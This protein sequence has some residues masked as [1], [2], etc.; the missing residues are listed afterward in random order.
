MDRDDIADKSQQV[1][2]L[3]ETHLG[4]RGAEL[5]S[6]VRKAGRRLP[7]A[8]RAQ[9]QVLIEA[10]ALPAHPKLMRR[11]DH[12][13]VDAAYTGLVTYLEAIDLAEARKTRRLNLAAGLAFN[14]LLVLVA[15]LLFF[16]WRGQS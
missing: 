8:Q 11:L 12:A 16:W 7:R 15:F 10:Q 1:A 6:A 9:A 13:A 14:L 5:A 2:A 3:M 4:T